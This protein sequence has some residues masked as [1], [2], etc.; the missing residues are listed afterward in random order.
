M[1]IVIKQQYATKV[2]T[3]NE[4]GA[5]LYKQQRATETTKA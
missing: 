2:L 3:C 4:I 1:H 5:M